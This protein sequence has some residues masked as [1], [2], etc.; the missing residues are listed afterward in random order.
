MGVGCKKAASISFIFCY[1]C[2]P[3]ILRILPFSVIKLIFSY[4]LFMHQL[5]RAGFETAYYKS[6]H[7]LN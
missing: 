1:S 7:R 3:I 2:I 6:R 4:M 5:I